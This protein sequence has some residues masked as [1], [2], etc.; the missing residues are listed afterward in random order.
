MA[1]QK[2]GQYRKEY[3]GYAIYEGPDVPTEHGKYIGKTPIYEQA[4]AACANAATRGK[5]Y[6]MKG[7]KKDGTQVVFL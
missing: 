5:I 6:I 1:K 3:V 2:Y 7:I 4:E